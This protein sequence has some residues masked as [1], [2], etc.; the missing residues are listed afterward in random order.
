MGV[1][2]YKIVSIKIS[3]YAKSHIPPTESD[4][5]VVSGAFQDCAGKLQSLFAGRKRTEKEKTFLK[6]ST[7]EVRITK[8]LPLAVVTSWVPAIAFA[9]NKNSDIAF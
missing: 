8:S 2:D 9:V 3:R 7:T 5:Y 4:G 1:N 6:N